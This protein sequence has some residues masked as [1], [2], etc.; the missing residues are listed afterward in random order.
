MSKLIS[1]V[2]PVY[3]EGAGLDVYYREM[4]KAVSTPRFAKYDVEVVLVDNASTDD[5][6]VHLEAIAAKDSRFKVIFNARNVG[7]YLSSFN[8]LQYA[9]GDAVFLLVPSDLQD[10]P[11][12]MDQM[13]AK[14][15]EGYLLIA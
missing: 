5:T 11:E 4:L 15:E 9:K 13:L 12:L 7:V 8:A 3:N 6:A 14:W 10:P 2:S 1:I